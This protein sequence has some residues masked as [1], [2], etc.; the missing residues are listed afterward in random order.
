MNIFIA[1]RIPLVIFI[2]YADISCDT[3][4]IEDASMHVYYTSFH[5]NNYVSRV[6][7]KL[8]GHNSLW[9]IVWQLYIAYTGAI[10]V[11]S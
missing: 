3:L 1:I 5:K 10:S 9:P 11:R 2:N 4:S 7:L 8:G 6:I